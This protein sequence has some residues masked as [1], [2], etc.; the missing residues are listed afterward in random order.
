M[1]NRHL[2]D[3]MSIHLHRP[4]LILCKGFYLCKHLK[5]DLLKFLPKYPIFDNIIIGILSK[6]FQLFSQYIETQWSFVY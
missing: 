2:N 1:Q 3:N 4:S 6:T 5:H